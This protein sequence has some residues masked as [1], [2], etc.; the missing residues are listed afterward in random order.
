MPG[1]RRSPRPGSSELRVFPVEG[2]A[3]EV[4][5]ECGGVDTSNR[6]CALTGSDDR[7]YFQSFENAVFM[8]SRIQQA[9][10]HVFGECGLWVPYE[11]MTEFN[12]LVRNFRQSPK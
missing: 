7:N 12:M 3:G 4:V 2:L 5:V 1:L 9:Q 6:N 8:L 11:R 10:L